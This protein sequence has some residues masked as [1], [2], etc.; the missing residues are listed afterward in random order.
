MDMNRNGIL[1][2]VIVVVLCGCVLG[3]ATGQA[4]RGQ[5][6]IT[7][8]PP[9]ALIE[10][11]GLAQAMIYTPH[12]MDTFPGPHTVRL[13]REGYQD[14]STAVD[15]T[16][17]GIS[18]VHGTLKPDPTPTTGSIKVT[19]SPPGASVYLDNAYKGVTPMTIPDVPTG[20]HTVELKLDGYSDWTTNV[21]VSSGSSQP[22]S[23]VMAKGPTPTPT[24]ESTATSG[25]FAICAL[26]ISGII[27]A[28]MRRYKKR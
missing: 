7:S 23:A 17:G 19:S 5:I 21:E 9:G 4:P 3:I 24:P 26:I 2:L 20:T 18:E 11:D 28:K 25:V 6:K 15:V 13:S 27:V 14:W 22:L 1:K 12:T 8:D 16:A 10:M